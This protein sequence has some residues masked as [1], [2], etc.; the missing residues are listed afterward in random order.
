[1]VFAW[2]MP[3]ALQQLQL[4][5]AAML[6]ADELFEGVQ[7]IVTRP[8]S[9]EDATLIQTTIDSALAGMV[10][11]E[12]TGGVFKGGLAIIIMMSEG[13]VP[14]P[15]APGPQLELVQTIRVIENPLV[16]MGDE[17]TLITAEQGALNVLATLHHWNPGHGVLIADGRSALKEVNL[18]GRV[19]YDVRFR[20]DAGITPRGFV[21]RPLIAIAETIMTITCGT[22]GA[23]IYWTADDS[24]PTP[25]T[26]TLYTEPVD[27]T[28]LLTGTTTL[29]A[30]AF[31]AGKRGSDITCKQI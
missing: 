22:P 17:G 9:E 20:R 21:Q 16:N 2:S 30:A 11:V 29:R 12:T 10:Q 14:A 19:S 13:E 28:A 26:G 31:L 15:N 5:I 6:A 4:D 23:A 24:A 3:D 25:A 18:E 1:M 27:V 8:R 7:I